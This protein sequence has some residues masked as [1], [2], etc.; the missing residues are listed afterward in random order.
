MPVDL[1]EMASSVENGFSPRLA[2]N[3]SSLSEGHFSEFSV[4]L[5][6]VSGRGARLVNW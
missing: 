2:R 4:A 5:L 1:R 6:R 3:A